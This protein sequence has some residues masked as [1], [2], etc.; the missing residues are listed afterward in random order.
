MSRILVAE[1][2]P[3]ILRVISLWLSRQGHEVLEAR[4][5]IMAWDLMQ[6]QRPEILIT[7]INMPGMDGLGL[8]EELKRHDHVPRGIVVLTNRWDHREIGH[9]LAKWGVRVVPKPFSPT[10]L[11]ELIRNLDA[12]VSLT[13]EAG[14]PDSP[15]TEQ[16]E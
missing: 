5:G 4:N 1:D 11:A 2:D 6:Q 10:R 12:R 8:L 13:R 9:D 16:H 7:D 15:P 14:R 3:H